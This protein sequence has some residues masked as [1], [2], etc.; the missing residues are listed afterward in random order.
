MWINALNK[1]PGILAIAIGDG[2]QNVLI[3]VDVCDGNGTEQNLHCTLPCDLAIFDALP[4]RV[5]Q[6]VKTVHN[7][8]QIY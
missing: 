7:F 6:R 1:F 5:D 2:M 4:E 8:A 3:A